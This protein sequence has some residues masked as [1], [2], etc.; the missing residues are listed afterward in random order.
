MYKNFLWFIVK[1]FNSLNCI[2]LND[3]FCLCSP[4]SIRVQFFF[5]IIYIWPFPQKIPDRLF[6]RDAVSVLVLSA[7]ASHQWMER[8]RS[9]RFKIRLNILFFLHLTKSISI[10][11]ILFFGFWNAIWDSN[12]YGIYP[13]DL[14]S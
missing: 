4:Q 1:F 10:M 13:M 8:N 7:A 5:M 12:S 3:L 9:S 11:I 6:K 2:Y 14:L